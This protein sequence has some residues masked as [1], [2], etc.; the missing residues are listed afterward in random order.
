MRFC[1]LTIVSVKK[2]EGDETK[3]SSA[4]GPLMICRELNT[5]LA[6]FDAIL[7]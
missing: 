7:N 3:I 2:K 6:L 5:D 4:G 1:S